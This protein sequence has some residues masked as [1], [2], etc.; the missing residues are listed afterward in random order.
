MD[1]SI[2]DACRHACFLAGWILKRSDPSALPI[3]QPTRFELVL[4]LM[5]AR[6]LGLQV[7]PMLPREVG[8]FMA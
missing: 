6:T 3:L 1:T 2:A 4:K 5:T 8:E 7:P